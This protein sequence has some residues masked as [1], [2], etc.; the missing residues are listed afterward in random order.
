MAQ[1]IVCKRTIPTERPPLVSNLVA[2]SAQRIPMGVNLDFIDPAKHDILLQYIGFGLLR[3]K[4]S[5]CLNI[6]PSC[7]DN[8]GSFTCIRIINEMT[9][10]WHEFNMS[11]S[12]R[13]GVLWYDGQNNCLSTNILGKQMSSTVG[14]FVFLHRSSQQKFLS[15]CRRAFPLVQLQLFTVKRKGKV[16]P[17]LN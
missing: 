16:V 15:Y 11:C 12:A 4:I 7:T 8:I 13:N 17:V 5:A 6:K 2:W 14:C 3:K 1:P 10:E 9:I